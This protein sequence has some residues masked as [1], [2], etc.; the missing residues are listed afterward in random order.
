MLCR[1]LDEAN[2]CNRTLKYYGSLCKLITGLAL[3]T[4][5]TYEYFFQEAAEELLRVKDL[6]KRLEHYNLMAE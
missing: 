1:L 3:T 5:F 4:Y 2:I 6:E